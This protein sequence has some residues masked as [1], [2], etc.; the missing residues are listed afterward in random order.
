MKFILCKI[1]IIIF[2][3]GCA[4]QQ[5]VIDSLT[6]P[7]KIIV[8]RE[9]YSQGKP[10]IKVDDKQ[11]HFAVFF[12]DGFKDTIQGYVDNKLVFE[13]F[14]DSHAGGY[15]TSDFSYDYKGDEEPLVLKMV[16]TTRNSCFDVK[17]DKKY[18]LVY[19]YLLE[20]DQW[21][22]WFTNFLHRT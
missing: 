17:I 7:G 5:R 8:E 16:S 10:R 21:T 4:N 11:N 9:N 22:I 20:G 13:K 15:Y 14:V 18:K 6:C 19:V 3:T 2:L 12:L 1:F